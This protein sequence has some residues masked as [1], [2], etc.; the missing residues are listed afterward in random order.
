MA[1]FIGRK[2]DW[3]QVSVC[4]EVYRGSVVLLRQHL[5]LFFMGGDTN[6]IGRGFAEMARSEA[7]N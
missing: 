3:G 4:R 2:I 6:L 5:A 1:I 7:A